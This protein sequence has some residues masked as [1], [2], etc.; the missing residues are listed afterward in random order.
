[1]MK[2]LKKLM[3][4]FWLCKSVKKDIKEDLEDLGEQIKNDPYDFV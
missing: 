1:M 2:V 3:K 4:I